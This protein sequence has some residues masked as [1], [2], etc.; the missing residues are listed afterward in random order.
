MMKKQIGYAGECQLDKET[1]AV[2][3]GL[4]IV[5]IMA[6][7]CGSWIDLSV[8]SHMLFAL[9]GIGVAVF[10]FLS[11][12]GLV[13]S[14][15][16]NGLHGFWRKRILSIWVS[17]VMIS[18][19]GYFVTGWVHEPI[20]V[21]LDLLLIRSLNPLGWYMTFIIVCYAEFYV[22]YRFVK[23]RNLRWILLGIASVAIFCF[24]SDLWAQQAV[25]F[26]AGLMVA[27]FGI[28]AGGVFL[29]SRLWLYRLPC[30]RSCMIPYPSG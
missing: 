14:Y 7:H 16:R 8:V 19:P 2:L 24:G 13:K 5:C 17:Y 12:Y 27:E 26:L 21:V 30:A 29:P 20:D 1:S 10:L 18:I 22:L 6:S 23:Y 25:S 4:A 11:A 3:K 9:G 28:I 15:E